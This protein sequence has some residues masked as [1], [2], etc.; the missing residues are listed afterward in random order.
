MC[1]LARMCSGLCS[2]PRPSRGIV[3][4]LVC[5]GC[6]IFQLICLLFLLPNLSLLASGRASLSV[7]TAPRQCHRKRAVGAGRGVWGKCLHLSEVHAWRMGQGA[8][9]GGHS[10][11]SAPSL[12]GFSAVSSIT[13]W[14]AGR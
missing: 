11:A 4:L 12:S 7:E 8:L 6:D 3:A 9:R 10:A 14:E 1:V 5:F 13:A 2:W